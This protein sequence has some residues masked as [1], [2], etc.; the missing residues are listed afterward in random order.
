ML[1][2]TPHGLDKLSEEFKQSLEFLTD[3]FKCP[4]DQSPQFLHQVQLHMGFNF[5]S[6]AAEETDEEAVSDDEIQYLGSNEPN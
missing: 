6:D 5:S 4:K 2:Y 3:T 1:R